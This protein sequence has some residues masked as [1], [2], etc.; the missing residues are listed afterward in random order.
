MIRDAAHFRPSGIPAAAEPAVG[1][2]YK[3][4]LPRRAVLRNVA[5]MVGIATAVSFAGPGTVDAAETS[6]RTAG[7]I[8]SVATLDDLP[9]IDPS[10]GLVDVRGHTA[11]GDGG[12]GLFVWRSVEI[13]PVATDGAI[14]IASHVRPGDG[15]WL[16]I[17]YDGTKVRPEWFGTLAEGTDHAPVV[18]KAIDFVVAEKG[19]LVDLGGRR[20]RCLSTIEMD[21]TLCILSGSAAVLDFSD[22]PEV[23]TSQSVGRVS[24]SDLG[25]LAAGAWRWQDGV[26]RLEGD[27]SS[28]L[29]IQRTL[30]RGERYRLDIQVEAL[31]GDPN[32]PF[33]RLTIGDAT[34]KADALRQIVRTAGRYAYD[35]EWEGSGDATLSL[36]SNSAVTID[37]FSLAP[38]GRRECLRIR[39][40]QDS[41]QYG[42]TWLQG[43][44]LYG[45]GRDRQRKTELEGIRFET[46]TPTRSSRLAVRDVVVEGFA[47]ALTLSDRCYLVQFAQSRFIGET[48]V[49]FLNGS[50]DAGENISFFGCI[51]GGGKIGILNGG[52][53]FNLFGTSINFTDQFY[54]GSGTLF[55]SGCH[56]ETE[57]TLRPDQY[58]FDVGS[59]RV[60]LE[61]GTI[62]VSGRDFKAGNQADHIVM[63]RS[64]LA[65]FTMNG[66]FCYNLRS[67]TNVF[68]A[69]PGTIQLTNLAGDAVKFVAS[70]PTQNAASN[71]FGPASRLDRDPIC[72]SVRLLD[73]EGRDD[74]SLGMIHRSADEGEKGEKGDVPAG[75]LEVTKDA[76]AGTPLFL[77]LMVPAKT[78]SRVSWSLD[79]KSVGSD[80]TRSLSIDLLYVQIMAEAAG[81]MGGWVAAKRPSPVDL[82]PRSEWLVVTGTTLDTREDEWSDGA[83]PSFATHIALRIDLSTFDRGE[84]ILLRSPYAGAV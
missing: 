59:G 51:L 67:R 76:S 7:A 30:T 44:R 75:R 21:P 9:E 81:R 73:A 71:L 60:A 82:S 12:G 61:G 35:F 8:S 56:F 63:T 29:V 24:L 64:R 65:G 1:E 28:P 6:A 69:G 41:P 45:P 54:V 49:H 77:W 38:R 25:S 3:P 43:V 68:A 14:R 50:E 19:G 15:H 66:T 4:D 48:A 58:L 34:G 23:D 80:E 57:R 36:T 13:G 16:R 22:C 27:E 46:E 39:S 84:R 31:E 32:N 18:Q 70:I 33:L 37:A 74:S 53:E 83:V 47:T 26:L 10:L 11:E 20:Y 62:L 2:G 72:L 79:L 42:H 40:R 5:G 78:G 17:A 52:A 55:A